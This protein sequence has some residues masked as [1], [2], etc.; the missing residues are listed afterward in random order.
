MI[1]NN[2]FYN[3]IVN[4]SKL[5]FTIFIISIIILFVAIPIPKFN[6]N[7]SGFNLEN[8]QEFIKYNRTDSIFKN[9]S[10]I[11]LEILP[12]SDERKSTHKAIESLKQKIKL[13]YKNA[14][15]ISPLTFYSKMIRHWKIKNNK[16]STFLK[17]AKQIPELN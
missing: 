3:K 13:K 6:G 2:Q 14:K 7:I 1:E 15:I 5:L 17:Q 8:N 11:Y 10:K 12:N 4:N 16:L 9:G